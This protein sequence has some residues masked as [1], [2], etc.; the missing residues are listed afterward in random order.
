M[1]AKNGT[2]AGEVHRTHKEIKE[3][4]GMQRQTREDQV[5]SQPSHS[6]NTLNTCYVPDTMC[7]KTA[8]TRSDPE[9]GQRIRKKTERV[10]S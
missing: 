2:A 3:S 1:C 6:V 9:K 5:K 4:T 7:Q 10:A 8:V